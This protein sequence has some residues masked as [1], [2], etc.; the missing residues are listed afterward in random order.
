MGYSDTHFLVS[1][2]L[3]W[4]D[5]DI[6][7][8]SIYEYYGVPFCNMDDL[9]SVDLYF[10]SNV[11]MDAILNYLMEGRGLVWRWCPP[12]SVIALL[13]ALLVISCSTNSKSFIGSK[14]RS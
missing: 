6:S 3:S 14:F 7:S 2:Y 4:A 8:S 12:S 1:R 13:K 5:V 10:F 11:D 9:S